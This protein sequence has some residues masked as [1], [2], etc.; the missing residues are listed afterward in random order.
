MA[1]M[2]KKSGGKFS[3][4][5]NDDE[6]FNYYSDLSVKERLSELLE[7]NRKIWIHINGAYPSV[8]EKTGGKISKLNTDEDDF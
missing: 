2:S 5:K 7:W 6:D 3:F 8:I 1:L 4:D